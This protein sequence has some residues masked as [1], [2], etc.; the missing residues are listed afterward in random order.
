MKKY[1]TVD[2]YRARVRGMP[3]KELEGLIDTF[4]I[5]RDSLT[6]EEMAIARIIDMEI[7]RRILAWEV[8]QV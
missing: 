3:T 4:T 7:E 1:L 5:H 8:A 2:Q 6:K